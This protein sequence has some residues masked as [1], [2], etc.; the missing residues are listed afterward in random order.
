MLIAQT[1]FDG[2]DRETLIDGFGDQLKVKSEPTEIH[3][4]IQKVML[5]F[6]PAPWLDHMYKIVGL[7]KLFPLLASPA[8][9]TV[10]AREYGVDDREFQ[11]LMGESDAFRPMPK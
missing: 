11:R 8:H 7:Q 4:D 5:L 10:L 1:F 9:R 6:T 2:V 3:M